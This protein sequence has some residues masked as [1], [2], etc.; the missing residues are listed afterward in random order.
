MKTHIKTN[1]EL[2]MDIINFSPN[3]ALSQIMIVEAIQQYVNKISK[4]TD[5]EIKEEPNPLVCMFA[6]RDCAKDIK[7]RMDSF[8]NLKK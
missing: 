6:W 4:L 3:G 1:E 5:Q 7:F 2:I 8:Y